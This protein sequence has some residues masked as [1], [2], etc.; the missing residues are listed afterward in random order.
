MYMYI[1]VN[2]KTLCN[3]QPFLYRNRFFVLISL[4]KELFLAYPKNLENFLQKN[5]KIESGIE[6]GDLFI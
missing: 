6:W 2:I 5:S 4:C 3:V 1:V